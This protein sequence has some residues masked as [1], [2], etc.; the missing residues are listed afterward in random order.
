MSTQVISTLE[1]C[2]GAL[3]KQSLGLHR[4]CHHSQLLNAL[5]ISKVTRTASKHVLTLYNQIFRTLSPVRDINC[6]FLSDFI[7]KNNFIHGTLLFRVIKLGV[8]PSKAAFDK[9]ARN[10]D[11]VV[12]GFIDSIRQMALSENYVKPW[13]AERNILKLLLRSY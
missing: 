12:D 8:S 2:Q 6:Y 4:S 11:P 1:S 7:L 3:V 5:N 9:T 13:S 10:D